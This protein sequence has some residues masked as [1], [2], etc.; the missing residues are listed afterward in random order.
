[1]LKTLAN[2]AATFRG[3]PAGAHVAIVV[4][5]VAAI[6]GDV[7][8]A[9][10]NFGLWLAATVCVA[11]VFT[12]GMAAFGLARRFAEPQTL[13]AGGAAVAAAHTGFAATSSFDDED[14]DDSDEV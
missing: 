14:S 7:S 2:L 3:L 6:A 12:L 10:A 4:A 8:L 5:I 9:Q 1:M 11:S 13:A